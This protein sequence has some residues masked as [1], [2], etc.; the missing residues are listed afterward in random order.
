MARLVYRSGPATTVN[1]TPRSGKDTIGRPGKSPGLSVFD[2]LERAARLGAKVI[3]IIDLDLLRPPL[4]AFP[5]VVDLGGSE[6]HL[7]IAPATA[8]GEVDLV[9]LEEWA[10]WRLSGQIH[11]FTRLVDR[12]VVG[13]EKGP[14]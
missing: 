11:E 3:Q 1:L 2:S 14:R 5:D 13:K 8:T 12:A 10:G 4:R 7:A 6:G 9:R